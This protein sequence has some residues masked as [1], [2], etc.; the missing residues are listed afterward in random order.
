M[1]S[2]PSFDFGMLVSRVVVSDQVEFKI[3]RNVS[4]EMLQKAQEFLMAMARLAL[5]DNPA[6]DDVQ[7]REECGSAVAIVVVRH[8]LDIAESHR[9]HRLGAL[10]GLYLALLVHAQDQ[11]VVRRI[12]I[13]P[14]DVADLF[15]EE[16]VGRELKALAAMWLQAEQREVAR[17]RALGD[18]GMRRYAPHQ[19]MR[20]AARTYDRAQLRPLRLTN[21]QGCIRPAHPVQPPPDHSRWASLL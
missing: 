17:D 12:K 5:G 21:H 7:G 16:R 10:Q 2:E 18:A 13:K 4:L 19:R 11:R 9:Q 15:D 1:A 14:N 6:V 20:Q 3:G 8:S